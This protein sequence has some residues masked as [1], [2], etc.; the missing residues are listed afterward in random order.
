M[1]AARTLDA[2]RDCLQR[3]RLLRP[4]ACLVAAVSGGSDSMALLAALHQ[5]QQEVGFALHICHVQHGLRGE[6][7]L[8][9]EQL[10]RDTCRQLNLPVHVHTADLGGDLHLPGMET[11]ARNCRRAFY[12]DTMAALSADALLLAHHQDD[13]AET[14]LLHLLRGAGSHGLGGMQEAVPFGGG[15]LLR[16]FLPL[17]KAQL[18]A[19]LLEWGIPYRE[20]ASNQ[21]TITPRNALRLSVLPELEQL[22][23][24]CTERMARAAG[25]LRQDDNALAGQAYTL[26]RSCRLETESGLYA[27]FLPGLQDTPVAVAVRALRQWV[28]AAFDR[29]GITRTEQSLSAEE[30]QALLTFALQGH[31]ATMN[32]P[33]GLQAYAGHRW[34]HLL[35]QDG[36]PLVSAPQPEAIP[37]E[38]L[39]RRLAAGRHTL[40]LP[41]WEHSPIDVSLHGQLRTPD[42]PPDTAKTAYVPL[43]LLP[44]CVLRTPRPG[45]TIH[46]LGAPGGKPLRRYLTDCKMDLPFRPHLPV[47]AHGDAILWIPGLC[48]AQVLA[49]Q[50]D[51]PC[52]CLTLTQNPP[53]LTTRKGDKHHG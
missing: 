20:D 44:E 11:R 49:Y 24:G 48:T 35:R 25:L 47:L 42:A 28:A 13:Q 6:D 33:G 46:P 12:A 22:F 17:S 39:K 18:R 4:D 34:L 30:S 23:P 38:K 26:V 45:D 31:Q 3:H 8:G 15:L 9:D 41:G 19:A 7:S 37:L 21:A 5:L 16:P 27:L 2:L 1:S 50:P 14:M 43:A 32:L 29:A 36:S 40:P 52:L 53:Y 51:T 10:V